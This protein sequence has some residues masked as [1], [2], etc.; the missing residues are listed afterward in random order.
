[1][2]NAKRL[3]GPGQAEKLKQ[4]QSTIDEIIGEIDRICRA[5][6]IPYFIYGGTLLGA[7]REGKFIPWDDDADLAMMYDDYLRFIEV[8]KTQLDEKYFCQ[9]CFTD[10]GY[11]TLILKIRKN[12]TYI[13]EEKYDGCTFHQGVYVDIMPLVYFPNHEKLGNIALKW[14]FML[15]QLCCFDHCRSKRKVTQ[16]LFHIAKKLP[17][18]FWVRVRRWM[19]EFC[20]KHSSHDNECSFASHY[21]PLRKR[22]MKSEWFAG[23]KDMEF[24]GMTLMAP[25]GSESYLVHLYGPDYMTPPPADKQVLHSNLDSL[26]L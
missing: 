4:L 25:I 5:N 8:C 18:K 3:M 7:T 22:V 2:S 15:H 9:T 26:R 21:R 6:Q 20:H 11:P 16:A 10:P 1:M 12:N 17:L 24:D 23:T 14:M 13:R 19:L